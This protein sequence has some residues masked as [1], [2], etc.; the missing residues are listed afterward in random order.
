MNS[1]I[2]LGADDYLSSNNYNYDMD[3]PIIVEGI[4]AENFDDIKEKSIK[5]FGQNAMIAILNEEG[6]PIDVLLKDLE[7][8]PRFIVKAAYFLYRDHYCFSDLMEIMKRLRDDDGCPWDKVQTHD[9]IKYNV[10]EEAY[11]LVEAIDLN[12]REK[13]IEEAGDVLLQA[14]FHGKIAEENENFD[15]HDIIN[16][17]CNKLVT[18]H[19]HVFGKVSA[20]SPD[21]AINSWDNAKNVEKSFSSYKDKLDSVPKTFGALMRAQKVQKIVRKSGFDFNSPEEAKGKIFEELEELAISKSEANLIWESGDLLFATINYLRMLGVEVETALN[22][23]T[24]RFIKRFNYIESQFK[25][26]GLEM[27]AEHFDLMEKYYQ[28]SKKFENQEK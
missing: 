16:N 7:Y 18:R 14:I 10:V 11:E 5:N 21:A 6:Q 9:S 19:P 3:M 15:V 23:S 24:E 4:T 1:F 20:D 26:K 13:M 27:K 28:E 8:V 25:S 22:Q 12:D 17:L 2:F